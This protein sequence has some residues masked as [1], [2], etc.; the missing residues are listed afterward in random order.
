[1]K[2]ANIQFTKIRAEKRNIKDMLKNSENHKNVYTSLCLK[3][4]VK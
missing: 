2:R 4:L 1:M 3:I